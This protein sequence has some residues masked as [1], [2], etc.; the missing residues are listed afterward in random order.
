MT[1]TINTTEEVVVEEVVVV[2]DPLE[3]A[4]TELPSTKL[5]HMS[6]DD[7]VKLI[8]DEYGIIQAAEE[9]VASKN[10]NRALQV[11]HKLAALRA[12]AKLLGKWKIRFSEFGLTISYETAALYL[13]VYDNWC[14]V[15]QLAEAAGVDSTHLTIDRCRKLLEK[16][17]KPPKEASGDGNAAGANDNQQQASSEGNGNGDAQGELT[18]EPPPTPPDVVIARLELTTDRM[19]AALTS[20]YV[21][22]Q[23]LDIAHQ[24][25][26]HLGYTMVPRSTAPATESSGLRR[27]LT[28]ASAEEQQ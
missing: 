9:E 22:D 17:K 20:T 6:T 26:E 7:L 28:K 13:R 3:V 19:V 10:L 8:N 2:E 5:I 25:A 4:V 1:D 27:R 21:R 15:L 11:A 12:K 24:L 23:L 14:L 18:L 16:P